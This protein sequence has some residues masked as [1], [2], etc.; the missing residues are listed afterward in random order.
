MVDYGLAI[1]V[2]DNGSGIDPQD[3][4]KIA[5]KHYTS[6]IQEFEDLENVVS[7][8]FRGEALSSLCAMAKMTIV[9]RGLLKRLH[10]QKKMHQK[11][12]G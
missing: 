5:L 7:Y 6:K 3:Y 4:E 12:Q 1:E 8:G 11:E 9:I 10:A 2:S